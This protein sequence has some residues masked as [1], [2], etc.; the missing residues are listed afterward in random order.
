MHPGIQ[1]GSAGKGNY[2][3]HSLAGTRV[4]CQQRPHTFG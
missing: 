1:N 3:S 4:H 2:C